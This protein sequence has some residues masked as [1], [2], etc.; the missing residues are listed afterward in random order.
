MHDDYDET[1]EYI[2][3]DGTVEAIRAAWRCTP[4]VSLSQLL[5]S[6]TSMPFCELS[7]AE[8]INEL[9]EFILQNHTQ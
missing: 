9:N 8:L 6:A 3:I 7:N 5:D 4:H 2:D 1:S